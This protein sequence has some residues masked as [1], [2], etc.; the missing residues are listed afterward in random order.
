MISTSHHDPAM[1]FEELAL[2]VFKING[3][4][5]DPWGYANADL[6]SNLF[7]PSEKGKSILNT[8]V[9]VAIWDNRTN[10]QL[11]QTLLETK[12]NIS[13]AREQGE[14]NELMHRLIETLNSNGY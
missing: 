2:A 14:L 3:R 7:E 8:I 6:A 12:E 9:D 5:S 11:V 13:A 10:G 1:H 4:A